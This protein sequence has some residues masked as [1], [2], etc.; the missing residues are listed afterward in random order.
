MS[1]SIRR[2]R[3]RSPRASGEVLDRSPADRAALR[4]HVLGVAH[5]RFNWE[6]QLETLFGLYHELYPAAPDAA[7]AIAAAGIATAIEEE[8]AP[9]EEPIPPGRALWFMAAPPAPGTPLPDDATVVVVDTSL[10]LRA[11]DASPRVLLL[12]DVVE[13]VLREHDLPAEAVTALDG[14]A[15]ASGIVELM[16][17]GGTSHWYGARLGHWSWILDQSVWL[18]ALDLLLADH[19]GTAV[20]V[21]DPDTD[22]LLAEAAAL[23]A[24]RDGITV[25]E[26]RSAVAGLFG[27]LPA[28]TRVYHPPSKPKAMGVRA[29][30][31]WRFRPPEPERRLRVIMRRVER[32]AAEPERPL[33]VVNAHVRQ[34]VETPDGAR[35][36]NIYLGP[37]ADR[38]RKTRLRPVEVELGCPSSTMPR[39]SPASR[40]RT[41]PGR[42][43]ATSSRC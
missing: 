15:E 8:T 14:W 29:R 43:P 19:P 17:V 34:R 35:M 2:G 25:V 30:L 40:R 5:R 31:S 13:R 10:V 22:P 9:T 6:A 23:V 39:R 4:A 18:G 33:L 36:M 32:L 1:S 16:A 41:R 42:S 24:A 20:L 37:I 3:S 11:V 21:L 28:R 7:T 27:G 26:R 12:R 38:L